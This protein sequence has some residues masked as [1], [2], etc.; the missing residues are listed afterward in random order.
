MPEDAETEV[1]HRPWPPAFP[2]AFVAATRARLDDRGVLVIAG[3]DGGTR[4]LLAA[5][6]AGLVDR[7]S[8]HR[9]VSRPG[10]AHRALFV[11]EQLWRGE[12][13]RGADLDTA[14]TRIREQL[15]GHAGPPCIVLADAELSDACLL[16]TS[17]SPRDCRKK[18]KIAYSKADVLSHAKLIIHPLFVL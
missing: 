2:Q 11:L 13:P 8:L 14:E 15:A 7:P 5:E 9:H 6:V 1:A 18:K 16:Y 10:D 12:L 3:T 17:P 4:D